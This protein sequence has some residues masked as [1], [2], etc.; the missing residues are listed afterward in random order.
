MG[1]I[2]NSYMP[3][4]TLPE[5]SVT[6]PESQNPPPGTSIVETVPETR[7]RRIT[8]RLHEAIQ[9]DNTLSPE[10]KQVEIITKNRKVTLKGRVHTEKERMDIDSKARAADDVI[11]V[12]NQI[13][14]IPPH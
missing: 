9:D 2:P 7:D 13:E 3:A 8:S 14:L 1:Q 11:D 5:E 6:I 10:A 12:D 4:P